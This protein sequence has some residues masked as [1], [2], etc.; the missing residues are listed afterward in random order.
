MIFVAKKLVI[1]RTRFVAHV[2]LCKLVVF[3]QLI[4]LCS[5]VNMWFI[6]DLPQA[7]GGGGPLHMTPLGR[8]GLRRNCLWKNP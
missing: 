1:L 7:G 5:N 8:K 6:A 3:E 4:K 2:F